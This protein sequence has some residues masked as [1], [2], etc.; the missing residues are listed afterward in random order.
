MF[1][2]VVL[3]CKCPKKRKAAL[4]LALTHQKATKILHGG[5][6]KNALKITT[7]III[8]DFCKA[9]LTTQW[10]LKVPLCDGHDAHIIVIKPQPVKQAC[11]HNKRPETKSNY[12]IGGPNGHKI[13]AWAATPK[14]PA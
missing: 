5:V 1:S 4:H 6:K 14:W 9:Q 10:V 8:C 11:T 7:I 3:S 12:I 2:I 13:A